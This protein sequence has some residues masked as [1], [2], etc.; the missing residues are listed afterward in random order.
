MAPSSTNPASKDKDDNNSSAS[1]HSRFAHLP[2]STSGPIDC[3]VHGTVLLNTP[4]F[5]KGSAHTEEE[6]D[7]FNLSGLLPQRVQTLDQQVARAYQQYSSQGDDLA[8][9]TFM[10]SL[11]DQ[12]SVLYHRVS[13]ILLLFSVVLQFF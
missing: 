11:K 13:A 9:N 8:K 4:Y 7:A 10:T 1:G 5:N 3:A 12:N 6:R 2:L